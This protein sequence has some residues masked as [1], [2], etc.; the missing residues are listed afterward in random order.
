M[1]LAT[2]P[3][4][5]GTTRMPAPPSNYKHILATYDRET[6]TLACNNCGGQTMSLKATG[7][8]T[9]DP[10]TGLGCLHNFEG[11]N[12]GRCYTVYTCTK[13]QATYGIDS[14]D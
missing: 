7:E 10:A 13:C 8:T 12:A 1:T 9:I 3:K 5:N 14:S 11:R 2:C 6:D 4:C